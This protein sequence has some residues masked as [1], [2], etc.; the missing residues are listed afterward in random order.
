MKKILAIA[1]AVLFSVASYAQDG[2]R[3]YNRYSDMDG[4]SAVYVSSAMFRLVGKLPEMSVG[5][6]GSVDFSKIVSS[7]NGLYLLNTESPSV[8][9][10]L[11][12][13]VEKFVKN[14]TYEMLMEVKDDGETVRIY[15]TGTG[16]D[17]TGFVLLALSGHECTFIC[18][19]GKMSRTQVEETLAAVLS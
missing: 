10:D 16:D 12:K 14:G 6:A 4:V 3:I 8:S 11:K 18:I 13:D 1:I 5:E 15:I 17:V 19:D 9:A 7:L 2:R